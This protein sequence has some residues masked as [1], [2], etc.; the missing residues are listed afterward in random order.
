MAKNKMVIP[1]ICGKGK[2]KFLGVQVIVTDFAMIAHELENIRINI[3]D[4]WDE[5]RNEEYVSVNKTLLVLQ[6]K[7]AKLRQHVIGVR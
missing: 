3:R 7:I 5:T 4:T 2:H 6:K 1:K